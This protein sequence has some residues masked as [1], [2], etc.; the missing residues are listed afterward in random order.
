ME[1]LIHN[2]I[3][4]AFKCNIDTDNLFSPYDFIDFHNRGQVTDMSSIQMTL[5]VHY[6]HNMYMHCMNK[7]LASFQNNMNGVDWSGM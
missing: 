7:P 3:I 1:P 4:N 6:A 2:T 5:N